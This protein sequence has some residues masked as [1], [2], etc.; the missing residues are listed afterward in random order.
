MSG[1]LQPHGL[2]QP[3]APLSMELS[4]QEYWSGLPFPSPGDLPDPGVDPGSPTLQADSLPS[5]P[6]GK[7]TCI[8]KYTEYTGGKYIPKWKQ[9]LSLKRLNLGNIQVSY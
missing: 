8:F 9:W 5:E 3:Q 1:S 7:C 4:R 6:T 2:L